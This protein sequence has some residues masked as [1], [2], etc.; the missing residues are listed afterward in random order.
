MTRQ[1]RARWLAFAT[2]AVVVLLAAVFAGLRNLYPAHGNHVAS[3]ERSPVPIATNTRIE[4]GRAAFQ[5]IGCATCH[6]AEGRGNPTL[7]LDGVGGR[8][9][10]EGLRASAFARSTVADRLPANVVQAKRVHA[11]DADAEALLDFL[12]YLR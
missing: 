8:L 6:S 7:P 4:A 1:S 5:R 10:R 2:A 11:S 3:P 12:Q 9:D